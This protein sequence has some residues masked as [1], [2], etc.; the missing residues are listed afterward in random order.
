[1]ARALGVRFLDAAGRE[2]PEGGGALHKLRRIEMDGLDPRVRRVKI[3]IACDVNNPLVGPRGASR[4]YGPQKGATPAMVCQLE[5]GLRHLAHVIRR[6]LGADIAGVPG[7]GAAGGLGGGLMVFLGGE[8]R[9]GVEIV[10]QTVRLEEKLRGCRLVIT[11][12]GRIDRQTAFGKVPMGVARVARRLGIPVIAIA[13]CVGEGAC[14]VVSEGIIAYFSARQEPPD[15]SAPIIRAGAALTE[16]AEQVG[17]VLG[18]AT[19]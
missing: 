9:R 14:H 4:I 12:E 2:I 8:L 5:R 7:A 6:D 16:C 17:R 18:L 19:S 3:V 13:G 15:G 10:T 11:G 1:M